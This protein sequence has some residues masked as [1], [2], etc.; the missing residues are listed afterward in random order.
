[1]STSTLPDN[2]ADRLSLIIHNTSGPLRERCIA[3]RAAPDAEKSAMYRALVA[4]VVGDATLINAH[5]WLEMLRPF[6]APG[7]HIS[8]PNDQK[9]D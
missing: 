8:I 1:M 6:L 4:D 9:R 2:L 5:R 7:A 3:I